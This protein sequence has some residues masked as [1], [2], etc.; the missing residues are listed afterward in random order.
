MSDP[1]ASTEAPRTPLW[2]PAGLIH[3][4]FCLAGLAVGLWTEAVFVD[5]HGPPAAALPTLRSLAVAQVLFGLLAWPVI[6]VRRGRQGPQRWL[7]PAG[8]LGLCLLSAGPFYVAAAWFADAVWTDALRTALYVACV[9]SFALAAGVW[10]STVRGSAEA[11]TL[12]HEEDARHR[13]DGGT[14]AA[15]LRRAGGTPGAAVVHLLCVLAAV[16]MPMAHYVALEFGTAPAANAIAR[17]SPSTFAWNTAG[18]RRGA[19]WPEPLWAAAFW[20]LLAVACASLR[21][22]LARKSR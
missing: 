10:L 4:A 13:D 17:L 9:W 7:P 6:A 15:G 19:W 14:E 12:C 5:R 11:P 21:A 1:P 18:P 8:E 20:P 16:G 22:M 2:R 3:L